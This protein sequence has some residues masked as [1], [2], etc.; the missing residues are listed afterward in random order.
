MKTVHSLLLLL[1]FPALL[2]AQAG[3]S[4]VS[5]LKLGTSAQGISMGDA[6]VAHVQ[7]ASATYYNPAGIRPGGEGNPGQIMLLHKE[8]ILDTRTEFL[9][10]S[11]ALGPSQA[12]GLS[13]NTT[14]VGDIEIRTRPG[15][16]DGTFDSR[17][18]AVGFSYALRLSDQLVA[19]A[20]GRYLYE[21]IL[22][23]QS[24]GFGIDLGVQYL[25]PLEHL[26]AGIMLANLGSMSEFR[27]EKSTLPSLL[28]LGGA[29]DGAWETLS[30]AYLIAADYQ[31]VFPT[32]QSLVS[33][34]GEMV[35]ERV[36]AV[37]A[38][39]V[40]GS[41]GRKFST[42]VGLRYGIAALDYAFAPLTSDLGSTH[43]FSL[44]VDL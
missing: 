44:F 42:G 22:V 29:Y 6:M 8:W 23:D 39:Y 17:S 31:L 15:P 32:G 1:I 33:L 28:R 35:F 9:G 18:Y 5:F 19:G 26:R 10:A 36:I 41:E 12:I 3:K 16:A 7:G 21:K 27:K 20:T 11:V 13:V 2:Y 37:R 38:G 34:G 25:T 24:S 4:G 30:S 43:T 40:L 14:T